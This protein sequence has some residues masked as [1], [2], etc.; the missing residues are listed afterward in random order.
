[1]M[2]TITANIT[3]P[4]MNAITATMILEPIGPLLSYT[5]SSSSEKVFLE[6]I[7]DSV[8]ISIITIR[9]P[10][11]TITIN[12]MLLT[13]KFNSNQ[14]TKLL[15]TNNPN[16]VSLNTDSPNLKLNMVN[17][18]T[19]NH[20]TEIL[21]INNHNIS[22]TNNQSS[23]TNHLNNNNSLEDMLSQLIKIPTKSKYTDLKI[24]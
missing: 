4:N 21:N 19:V 16:T 9:I 11:S 1:M 23:I 15:L 3:A 14:S 5:S 17:L 7:L 13:Y 6:N 10:L 24:F 8:N 2:T 12:L 20:N 18:S 22:S